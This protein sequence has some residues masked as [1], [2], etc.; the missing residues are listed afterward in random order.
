MLATRNE[1]AMSLTAWKASTERT[2][3]LAARHEVLQSKVHVALAE[4]KAAERHTDIVAARERVLHARGVPTSPEYL[5]AQLKMW[6][7]DKPD[8]FLAARASVLQARQ[9]MELGGGLEAHVAAAL[10]EWEIRE[11]PADV[12]SAWDKLL[13]AKKALASS[14]ARTVLS[15]A[16]KIEEQGESGLEVVAWRVSEKEWQP[17][18]TTCVLPPSNLEASMP[19]GGAVEDKLLLGEAPIAA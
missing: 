8:D 14:N 17:S 13:A 1:L 2:Q 3:V 4:W 16:S 10:A 18:E 7:C 12:S 11:L 6:F 5:Q 9:L 15:D 19:S